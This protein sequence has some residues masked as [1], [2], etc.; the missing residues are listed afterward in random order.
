MQLIKKLDM[1]YDTEKSKCKSRFGLFECPV[2]KIEVEVRV[3]SGK[4]SAACWE[5]SKVAHGGC[6]TRIYMAWSNMRQRCNNKNNTAYKNYGGRGITIHEAWADFAVFRDWALANGYSDDLTIDRINND[7][8]YSPDNCRFVNRSVQMRN[9]RTINSTNTSGYRGV[10][11]NKSSGR[12]RSKIRDGGKTVHLGYFDSSL[13]A[14]K[15]Y[16]YYVLKNGLEHTTN[17]VI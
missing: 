12:W 13:D 8:G 7:E 16:D 11:W 5:C 9:T 6:G 15:A 4:R 1:R 14:A 2:C 10:N 17:N 3:T